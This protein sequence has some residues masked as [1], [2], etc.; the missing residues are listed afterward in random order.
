MTTAE[1]LERQLA[2]AKAQVD[3]RQEAFLIALKVAEELLELGGPEVRNR[4]NLLVWGQLQT[5]IQ[6]LRREVHNQ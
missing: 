6:L 5:T 3:D 4:Q 2:E 1:E